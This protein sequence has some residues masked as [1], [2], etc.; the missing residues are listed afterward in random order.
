MEEEVTMCDAA[1]VKKIVATE[2]SPIASDV[3]YISRSVD[4]LRKNLSEL[5]C[6]KINEDLI[7]LQ[8]KVESIQDTRKTDKKDID[9]LYRMNRDN[10]NRIATLTEQNKGQDAGS[11]RIWTIIM[12]VITVAFNIVGYL[13]R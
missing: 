12:V 8:V 6:S 1:E 5:P 11:A 10:E 2:I 13:L 3:K 9:T 4:E 7:R